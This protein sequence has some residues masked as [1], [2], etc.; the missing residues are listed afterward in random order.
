MSGVTGLV[1]TSVADKLAQRPDLV[2]LPTASVVPGLDPVFHVA[3]VANEVRIQS[4]AARAR[5]MFGGAGSP[6]S[7][8]T[9]TAAPGPADELSMAA[10]AISA[11]L[12]D[13]AGPAR[14][15]TGAG[16]LAPDGAATAAQALA[17][18]LATALSG[19]GLFYE[20]HLA[21]F[22]A[23]LLQRNDLDLEPQARLPAT[24]GSAAAPGP[25]RPDGIGPNPAAVE[26]PDTATSAIV[27][28]QA[29]AVVSQQLDL[30]ASG[31]FQ[32]RGEAWPGVPLQWSVEEDRSAPQGSDEAGA[33]R[34]WTTALSLAMPDLGVVDVRLRLSGTTLAAALTVDPAAATR[35]RQRAGELQE[36]LAALGLDLPL[37]A[38]E[39]RGAP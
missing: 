10:R 39:T 17:R 36:H 28:P 21:A 7:H 24:A 5:Q 13:L 20:S 32:W 3:A 15:V 11:V 14:P 9:G 6:A 2:R 18:S 23:G 22:S 8:P 35:L 16:P 34:C 29:R 12:A 25:A 4:D 26:A 1:D 30:L 37:V 31:V 19:S 27:H 33:A 38:I